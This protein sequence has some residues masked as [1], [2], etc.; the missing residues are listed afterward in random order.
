MADN[1]SEWQIVPSTA[2]K[3]VSFEWTKE[4]QHTYGKLKDRLVATSVL[5]Y[6]TINEQFVVE[7]N[8]NIR[9]AVLAKCKRI[10]GCT[11]WYIQVVL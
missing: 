11:H 6:P 9:G 2:P 1:S 3:D 8:A 10:N 4:C 5:D 7:T